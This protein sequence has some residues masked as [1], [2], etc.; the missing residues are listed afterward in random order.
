MS[1]GRRKA[2]NIWKGRLKYFL[3]STQAK[4]LQLYDAVLAYSHFEE[5]EREL[6]GLEK[7]A[8]A[9]KSLKALQR[10]Q[11]Q[12]RMKVNAERTRRAQEKIGRA[13]WRERV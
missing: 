12:T 13:S 9:S 4:E 5:K 6:E 2:K 8:Q 7:Q 10:L 1:R 3:L 11:D